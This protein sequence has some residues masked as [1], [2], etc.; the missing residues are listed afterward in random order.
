SLAA[1]VL[2]VMAGVAR[3]QGEATVKAEVN[4]TR[5]YVGDSLTLQVAVEGARSAVPP[6]L[7]K[8]DGF[9]AQY[10]GAQDASSQSVTIINGRMQRNDSL[11]FIMQWRLTPTRKGKLTIPALTVAAGGQNHATEPISIA[12]VEPA[13]SPDFRLALEADKTAAY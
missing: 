8:L 11:R 1:V 4:A 10:V 13:E 2:G 3:S 9:T 12:S 6:D 5:V 7:S